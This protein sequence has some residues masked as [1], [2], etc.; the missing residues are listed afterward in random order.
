[1]NSCVQPV[2][3]SLENHVYSYPHVFH[4]FVFIPAKR[5]VLHILSPLWNKPSPHFP[6]TFSQPILPKTKGVGM[7]VFHFST[8]LIITII[9]YI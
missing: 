2:N 5:A 3:K 4:N 9:I 1:M 6:L 8:L 7:Q